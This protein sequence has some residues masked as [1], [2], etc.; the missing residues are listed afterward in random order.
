[1]SHHLHRR[2]E[3]GEPLPETPMPLSPEQLDWFTEQTERAADKAAHRATRIISRSATLGFLI[4]LLGIIY[5][6]HTSNAQNSDGRDAIVSSGRTVAVDGCNRDYQDRVQFIELLLRGE[7]AVIVAHKAG[8]TSNAQY[9]QG[10]AFY[11]RQLKEYP[12]LDCRKAESVIT[13]DPE[14]ASQ[15]PEPFWPGTPE[16]PEVTVP[17]GVQYKPTT[18]TG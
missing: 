10:I 4:L 14:K 1:M 13:A 17:P 11:E 15:P 2:A 7:Q 6:F 16:A 5:V 3:D 12:L 8:T 9:A 18:E